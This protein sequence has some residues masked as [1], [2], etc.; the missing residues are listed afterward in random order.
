[1]ECRHEG[2]GTLSVQLTDQRSR[3]GLQGYQVG[4]DDA[5]FAVGPQQ[6]PLGAPGLRDPK[7][8]RL[9]QVNRPLPTLGKII[10]GSRS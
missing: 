1:M 5:G 2:G 9:N 3:T 10:V 8:C 6:V 7:A 4:R